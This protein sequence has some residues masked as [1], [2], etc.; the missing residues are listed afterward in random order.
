MDDPPP[1]WL[2]QPGGWDQYE[3][4]NWT[5]PVCEGGY[6]WNSCINWEPE[7]EPLA[8]IDNPEGIS[9]EN[10]KAVLHTYSSVM[11]FFLVVTGIKM[12]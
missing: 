5:M 9:C 7:P 4:Y 1:D 10:D 3:W 6:Y 8:W 2:P 11:F 12:I